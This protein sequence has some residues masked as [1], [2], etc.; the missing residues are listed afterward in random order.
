MKMLT[1]VVCL[2]MVDCN[3]QESD[4]FMFVIHWWVLYPLIVVGLEQM[5]LQERRKEGR[6]FSILALTDQS[7]VTETL[8]SSLIGN[9]TSKKL[10]PLLGL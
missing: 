1:S 2:L 6:E 5:W 10:V 4:D 9:F 8:R 3:I 7:Q